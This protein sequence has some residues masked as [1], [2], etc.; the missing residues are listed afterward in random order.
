MGKGKHQSP[1]HSKTAVPGLVY[2][3]PNATCVP[4]GAVM[5]GPQ[6]GAR[7]RAHALS[8]GSGGSSRAVFLPEA[9]GETPSP[10][11]SGVEGPP[12]SPGL[13]SPKAHNLHSVPPVALSLVIFLRLDSPTSLSHLPMSLQIHWIHPDNPGYSPI[14]KS[15]P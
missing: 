2:T 13:Q 15:L 1:S 11:L 9:L 4:H 5:N 6:G 7:N 3:V 12:S 8:G 10:C 14:P